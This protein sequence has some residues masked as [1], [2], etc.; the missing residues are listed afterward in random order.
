M[1]Y[2]L[3]TITLAPASI[4]TTPPRSRGAI[5]SPLLTKIAANGSGH[6][7]RRKIEGFYPN[8]RH[9][10]CRISTQTDHHKARVDELNRKIQSKGYRNEDY[11]FKFS[12]S[13]GN[14]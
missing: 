14:L 4:G 5:I 6:L 7:K 1:V 12:C 8:K 2:V 11:Q 3:C 13:A 9:W 10:Q